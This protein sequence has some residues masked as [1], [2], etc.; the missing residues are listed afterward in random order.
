MGC[1]SGL[2][3]ARRDSVCCCVPVYDVI[4]LDC[5]RSAHAS[6]IKSIS[7]AA[8]QRRLQSRMV[9]PERLRIRVGPFACLLP[10]MP[11]NQSI[12]FFP[13]FRAAYLSDTEAPDL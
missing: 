12:T 13:G 3:L 2:M 5:S 6:G 7:V 8:I 11:R 10:P 1:M 4:I 9:S